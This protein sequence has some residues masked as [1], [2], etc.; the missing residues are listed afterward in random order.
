[1]S[2]EESKQSKYQ[3]KKEAET[4]QNFHSMKDKLEILEREYMIIN[5]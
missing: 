3:E 5:E 2:L 1:M 4:N